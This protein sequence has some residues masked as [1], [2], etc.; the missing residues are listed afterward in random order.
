[1]WNCIIPVNFTYNEKTS[2]VYTQA[3]R[4]CIE[5]DTICQVIPHPK[6]L[7]I[8]IPPCITGELS[9]PTKKN[10]YGIALI[11]A[12]NDFLYCDDAREMI[13]KLIPENTR[14]LSKQE[15]QTNVFRFIGIGSTFVNLIARL[16]SSNEQVNSNDTDCVVLLNPDFD[17]ETYN[18]IYNG[19][20]SIITSIL[21]PINDLQSDTVD[22]RTLKTKLFYMTS[23]VNVSFFE[24]Y[25]YFPRNMHTLENK[26]IHLNISLFKVHEY[27]ISNTII[28]VVVY[29]RNNSRLRELWDLF[30]L[31]PSEFHGVP[32]PNPIV[33]LIEMYNAS[34]LDNRNEIDG[35]KGLSRIAKVNF[36]KRIIPQKNVDLFVANTKN[37]N[38][39]SIIKELYQ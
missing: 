32:F 24:N 29:L 12:L 13:S 21:C 36:L 6:N 20:I 14:I 39:L 34:K 38:I 1:M 37:V 16:Y 8:A 31:D 4:F 23:P 2:L 22:I 17:E 3:I 33:V 15:M 18:K 19:I 26:R 35:G 5:T 27:M 11:I 10:V 30:A 9:L 25:G 28:D 7:P